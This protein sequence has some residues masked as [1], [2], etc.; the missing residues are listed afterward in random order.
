MSKNMS[1]RWTSVIRRDF[2]V[3]Y[4]TWLPFGQPIELGSYGRIEDGKWI[5]IRHCSD[6]AGKD[7]KRIDPTSYGIETA[8]SGVLELSEEASLAIGFSPDFNAPG[9]GSGRATVRFTSESS[10]LARAPSYAIKQIR[11]RVRFADELYEVL[12]A[13]DYNKQLHD[14]VVWQ[15]ME[16]QE[17]YFLG[18]TAS[19]SETALEGHYTSMSA[20]MMTGGLG[21]SVV[22]NEA[23][24]LRAD[25]PPAGRS[26]TAVMAFSVLRWKSAG[27]PVWDY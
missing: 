9:H 7:G 1:E 6:F 19:G 11:D 20:G 14:C 13:D 23:H 24:T 26:G 3:G 27:K 5:P 12:K 21:F 22:S 16:V 15:V 8:G 18:S 17:G 4:G 10:F 25:F 2:N